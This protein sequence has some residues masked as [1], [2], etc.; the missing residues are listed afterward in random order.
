LAISAS[1]VA[2]LV[3][4]ESFDYDAGLID[5]T[6]AGGVGFDGAWSTTVSRGSGFFDINTSGLTFSGLEVAGN[7][8]QRSGATGDA[9]ANRAISAASQ[10][11]LLADNTTIWFS[12]LYQ[13]T[14][15]SKKSAFIIGTDKLVKDELVAAGEGFGFGERKDGTTIRAFAYDDSITATEDDSGINAVTVKLIVGKINWKANGTND[16]LYLYDVTDLSTEPTTPIATV[17]ADLIQ[18]NFDLV[19]LAENGDTAVFDEIRFG[20]TF[21]DVTPAPEPM[22]LA[23]LGLGGLTLLR[24]RR[25]G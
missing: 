21:A 16:E 17:T 6:Q 13:Q 19:A 18:A 23:L 8:V 3:I 20:T 10:A 4:Y 7:S 1:V 24:R 14:D 15:A 12:V 22:T 9:E 2:D 5:G 11:A 25:N